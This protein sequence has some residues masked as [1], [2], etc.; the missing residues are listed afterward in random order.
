MVAIIV[1]VNFYCCILGGLF[2]RKF[3]VARKFYK[4]QGIGFDGGFLA[5]DYVNL[6][7]VPH[8]CRK[9]HASPTDHFP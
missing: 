6:H 2:L 7:T 9:F 5:S 3:G 4:S 8:E 1:G